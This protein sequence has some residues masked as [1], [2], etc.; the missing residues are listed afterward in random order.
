MLFTFRQPWLLLSALFLSSLIFLCSAQQDDL[1]WQFGRQT[2]CNTDQNPYCAG[3]S[4][5]EALC[6]PYPSVS[7]KNVEDREPSDA[8]TFRFATGLAE[9]GQQGAV[10]LGKCV[11]L[12][13]QSLRL[14]RL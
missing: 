14:L 7:P 9:T 4:E 1:H 8:F 2:S 6:C 13:G 12:P 3:N 5:F 10:L 11:A